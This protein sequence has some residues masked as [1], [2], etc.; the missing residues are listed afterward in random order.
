VKIT[1]VKRFFIE[2][3]QAPSWFGVFLNKFNL[4][5]EQ[6]SDSLTHNLTIQD[7][8]DAQIHTFSILAG[9][10]AD[11]NTTEFESTMTGKPVAVI[12]GAAS[13][14]YTAMINPVQVFWRLD[15]KTIKINSITGL[16]SGLEYK[17]NLL[18][19]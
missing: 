9:A 11:L 19:M 16:T 8:M 13:S 4:L 14:G 12:V 2:Q 3:F 15:G 5:L 6:I 10:T 17:L 7:N 18:I 1:S